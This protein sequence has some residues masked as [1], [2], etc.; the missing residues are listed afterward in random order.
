MQDL[1]GGGNKLVIEKMN[2]EDD[3]LRCLRNCTKELC[4]VDTIQGERDKRQVRRGRD[5]LLRVSTIEI[6]E[7]ERNKSRFKMN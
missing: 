2:D 6:R 5:V 7:K 3:D 4:F 1:I